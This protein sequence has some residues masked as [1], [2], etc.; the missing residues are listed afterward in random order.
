MIWQDLFLIRYHVLITAKAKV[1]AVISKALYTCIGFAEQFHQDGLDNI[2]MDSMTHPNLINCVTVSVSCLTRW[3]AKGHPLAIGK[4]AASF[5]FPVHIQGTCLGFDSET[6]WQ[7]IKSRC[8]TE[9]IS[10]R[11]GMVV[12]VQ[13]CTLQQHKI[14]IITKLCCPH[15]SWT[16]RRVGSR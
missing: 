3:S 6:V 11:R 12:N 1:C 14:I 15:L 4:L 7:V 13:R 2:K 5:S 9:L 8:V 16:R 10:K